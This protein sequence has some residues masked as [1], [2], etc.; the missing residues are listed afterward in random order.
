[1]PRLTEEMQRPQLPFLMNSL[2][3]IAILAVGSLCSYLF[4]DESLRSWL[5]PSS[6]P[7][8]LKALFNYLS[9]FGHGAGCLIAILLILNFDFERRRGIWLVLGSTIIA[10]TVTAIVKVLVQRARPFY[11]ASGADLTIN[12]ALSN[13][14]MHSFPSGHTATAFS[15]ALAISIL[16][17]RAQ[18]LMLTLAAITALQRVVSQSHYVSDIFAGMVVGILSVHAALFFLQRFQVDFL[19]PTNRLSTK[20]AIRSYGMEATQVEGSR[21]RMEPHA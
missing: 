20:P 7:G 9:A 11:E 6:L 3:T 19:R 5:Q 2:P 16:Y 13:N 15:L 4:V 10:G 18:K 1:M 21:A 8:D 12:E 17:P 14:A